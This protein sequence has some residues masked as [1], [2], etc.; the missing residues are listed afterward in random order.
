MPPEY[1]LNKYVDIAHH[2][3][4]YCCYCNVNSSGEM[5]KEEDV[6]G[7]CSRVVDLWV[8]LVG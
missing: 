1:G 3:H 6:V 4:V 8:P 5:M 2:E 7:I